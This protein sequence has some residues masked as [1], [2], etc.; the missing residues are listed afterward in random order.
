MR[1]LAGA[2][3]EVDG[4][5]DV[6]T[7]ANIQLRGLALEDCEDVYQGLYGQGLTSVQSGMDNV[8]NMT[9]NPLAG[10]DPEE[11]IDTRPLC[12]AIDDMV[13]VAG[14]GQRWHDSLVARQ[15]AA[16]AV[17]AVSWLTITRI[18]DVQREDAWCCPALVLMAT[19]VPAPIPML[20]REWVPVQR[21]RA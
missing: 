1:F 17:R 16:S 5:A 10:I 11:I 4:C 12:Q 20:R 13:S 14:P 6:T 7:R 21:R 8:R 2:V 18:S 9:G 19:P 3:K 15:L